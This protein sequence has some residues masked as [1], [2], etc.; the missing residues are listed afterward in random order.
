L[1]NIN[2]VLNQIVFAYKIR[3]TGG[4]LFISRGKGVMIGLVRSMYLDQ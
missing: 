2:I 3:S 1:S 4:F